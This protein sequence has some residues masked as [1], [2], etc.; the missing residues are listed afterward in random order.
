MRACIPQAL[1]ARAAK[2]SPIDPEPVAAAGEVPSV[3][4]A[5]AIGLQHALLALPSMAI[6]A[7]L[8]AAYSLVYG[9]VGRINFAFGELAAVGSYAAFPAFALAGTV[10][11]VLFP[12][13]RRWRWRLPPRCC[14]AL[15]Q[16][17]S[18]LR[19]CCGS[20]VSSC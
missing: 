7:L 15:S 14:T 4:R 5:V 20:T 17:A 8:A 13:P 10:S 12:G 6:Y 3:P 1:L 19:R 11:T 18:C 9:L 2:A 16:A